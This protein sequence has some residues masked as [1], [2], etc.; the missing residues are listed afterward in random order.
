[1]PRRDRGGGHMCASPPLD[2]QQ[3]QDRFTDIVRHAGLVE[4]LR[5]IA[6]RCFAVDRDDRVAEGLAAAW[7]AFYYKAL[8]QGVLLDP[9]LY[10]YYR[11]LGQYLQS[12]ATGAGSR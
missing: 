3:L 1:M 2:L 4:S 7:R 9:A 8:R 6:S 5:R 10:K 12:T 11:L